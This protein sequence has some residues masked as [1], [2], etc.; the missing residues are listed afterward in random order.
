LPLRPP[1]SSLISR[2]N[3]SIFNTSRQNLKIPAAE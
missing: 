1:V 3:L 2:N